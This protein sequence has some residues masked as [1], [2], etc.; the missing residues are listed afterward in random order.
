M[1]RQFLNL[2]EQFRGHAAECECL[3]SHWREEGKR[4]Y[5]ELAR[6]WLKLA[7]CAIEQSRETR[8]RG[9]IAHYSRLRFGTA[10]V[11]RGAP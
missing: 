9:A 10:A 6:Q 7:E 1:T 3:A 8:P 11:P 4:Q 5:E 2:A